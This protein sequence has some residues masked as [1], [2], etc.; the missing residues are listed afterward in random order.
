MTSHTVSVFKTLVAYIALRFRS[1]R[2]LLI[3]YEPVWAVGGGG[4]GL[5]WNSRFQTKRRKTIITNKTK[6][7]KSKI[8]YYI[9]R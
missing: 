3:L 5:I 4:G 2:D 7:K 9:L 6:K 1:F 8:K